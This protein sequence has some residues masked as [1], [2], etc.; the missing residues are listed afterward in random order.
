MQ[1]EVANAMSTSEAQ[2]AKAKQEIINV[3]IEVGEKLLPLVS[4]LA[5]AVGGVAGAVGAITEEFP[6]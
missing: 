1:K 4:L 5:S 3:A 6:F 2:I